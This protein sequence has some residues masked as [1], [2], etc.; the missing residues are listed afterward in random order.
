[1]KYYN[2]QKAHMIELENIS[3]II[4]EFKNEE[5]KELISY[6]VKTGLETIENSKLIKNKQIKLFK[7]ILTYIPEKDIDDIIENIIKIKIKQTRAEILDLVIS[8]YSVERRYISKPEK[9]IETIVEDIYETFDLKKSTEDYLI[10]NKLASIYNEM[11]CNEIHHIFCSCEKYNTAG[12]QF[13]LNMVFYKESLI[14]YVK[15]DF[16]SYFK[17]IIKRFNEGKNMKIEEIYKIYNDMC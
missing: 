6:Y 5:K 1:M 2:K 8:D 16:D 3:K 14:N 15:Y 17:I 9:W 11:L 10:T 7:H 13:L 12:N 4:N